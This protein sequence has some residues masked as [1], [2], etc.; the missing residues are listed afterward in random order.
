MNIIAI[1]SESL[2]VKGIHKF[3][4]KIYLYNPLGIMIEENLALY[5]QPIRIIEIA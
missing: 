4:I 2:L 5:S 3:Y 1:I